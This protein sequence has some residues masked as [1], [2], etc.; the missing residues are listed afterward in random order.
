MSQELSE[1]IVD[2]DIAMENVFHNLNRDRA[3]VEIDPLRRAV[4]GHPLPVV[5]KEINRSAIGPDRRDRPERVFLEKLDRFPLWRKFC[6]RTI[7]RQRG[8]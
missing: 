6:N 8:E 3:I 2:Q 1:D 7:P 5:I 4:K